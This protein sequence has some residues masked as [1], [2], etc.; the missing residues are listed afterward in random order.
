MNKLPPSVPGGS[1]IIHTIFAE[2]EETGDDM[3]VCGCKDTVLCEI[4]YSN[5]TNRG[6]TGLAK[7]LCLYTGLTASVESIRSSS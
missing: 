2:W 3:F 1:S 5:Q 4:H 7:K 6:T